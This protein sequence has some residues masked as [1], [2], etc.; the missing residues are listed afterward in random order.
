MDAVAVFVNDFDF[1]AQV[2]GI[3]P[4]CERRKRFFN[5]ATAVGRFA[6]FVAYKLFNRFF[7]RAEVYA[8]DKEFG[9]VGFCEFCALCLIRFR[10]FERDRVCIC[11]PF[12]E[13]GDVFAV[14]D[15]YVEVPFIFGF[16]AYFDRFA[17]VVNG[18]SVFVKAVVDFGRFVS[19]AR[20]RFIG[21]IIFSFIQ[22]DFSAVFVDVCEPSV[23]VFVRKVVFI[24]D[25]H[26]DI[27]AVFVRVDNLSFIV[28]FF[29]RVIIPA[30][31]G[32]S[33]V[34]GD[35]RRG[36]LLSLCD[37]GNR[38]PGLVIT[39]NSYDAH[40]VFRFKIYVDFVNSGDFAVFRNRF[41]IVNVVAV[42]KVYDKVCCVVVYGQAAFFVLPYRIRG[43][44]ACRF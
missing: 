13:H 26:K 1:V 12:T 17:F 38:Y 11:C 16:R 33:D 40:V 31:E 4:A 23:A 32:V 36:G 5:R 2:V 29:F 8:A 20:A 7:G 44:R 35:A 21:Q 14:N 10:D 15:V 6:D 37:V 27:A 41:D 28:S 19:K 9:F 34:R 42:F 30:V 39:L 22:N 24:A 18:Q 3:I 25:F 43:F